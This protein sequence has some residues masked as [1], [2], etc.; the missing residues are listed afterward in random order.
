MAVANV[1]LHIT[2][3]VVRMTLRA[4]LQSAGHV[5]SAGSSDVTVTDSP[6]EAVALAPDSPV[7]LVTPAEGIADAVAAMR[8]G[9]YGYI[10]LPFQPGEADLMVLRAASAG[11]SARVSESVS[12]GSATL[13][14]VESR[15]IRAVMR[16]CRNNRARASAVLGIGRNTLW[17]KLNA[18]KQSGTR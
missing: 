3:P 1:E 14:E 10:Y 7:L 4:I 12:D 13:A 5:V 8:Q 2:D 11:V 6:G 15:H 18:M 16:Q 17:R 9:V